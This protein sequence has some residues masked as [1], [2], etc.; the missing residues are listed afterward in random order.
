[1]PSHGESESPPRARPATRR[2]ARARRRPPR[3]G[4]TP[5]KARAPRPADLDRNPVARQ[6]DSAH[7][8]F[9]RGLPAPERR[10]VAAAER[11]V[12]GALAA[13]EEPVRFRVLRSGLDDAAKAAVLARVAPLTQPCAP[14]SPESAKL[15]R[16]LD[17][18]LGVP[19]GV[20]RPPPVA[21]GAPAEE[22]RRHLRAARA[23]LD[24]SVH[25][26]EHAKEEVMRLLAKSFSNPGARGLAIGLHGPAG[27]GKTTLLNCIGRALGV[28]TARIALGG[29][30]DGAHL[31]GNMYVYEGSGPGEVVRCLTRARTMNC[32]MCFDELDK[33]SKTPKGDEVANILMNLTDHATNGQFYDKFLGDVSVDLSR[34]VYAFSMNDPSQVSPILLDRMQLIET[35]GYGFDDKLRIARDHLLPEICRDHGF[36]E[37]AFSV[38]ADELRRIIAQAPPEDGV[39]SLARAL[40]GAVA[41]ENLAR[42]IGDRPEQPNAAHP[43]PITAEMVRAAA[44]ARAHLDPPFPMYS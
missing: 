13:T 40:R 29:A 15:R 11:G 37:D 36:R 6:Y 33:V 41:H 32:L 10:R 20:V 21:P 3:R 14:F 26:H 2:S 19:H 39:R 18:V 23:D 4:H 28:P 38:G 17:A 16:W 5:P 35:R 34:V 25:G 31:E 42:L 44:P 8:A 12:A 22:V 1:M 7:M 43:T 9:Y 27:V 30:A 24:T